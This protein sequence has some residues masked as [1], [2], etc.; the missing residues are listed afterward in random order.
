MNWVGLVVGY[1]LIGI[2]ITVITN[3]FRLWTDDM[4]E[5]PGFLGLIALMW[6]FVL[7]AMIGVGVVWVIGS[8]IQLLGG[9]KHEGPSR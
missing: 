7:I 6:P 1:L 5:S 9:E 4:E 3:R 8:A 2:F